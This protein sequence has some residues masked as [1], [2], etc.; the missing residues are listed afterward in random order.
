MRHAGNAYFSTALVFG[1]LAVEHPHLDRHALAVLPHSSHDS[2]HTRIAARRLSA[3]SD[4]SLTCA[5]DLD[6]IAKPWS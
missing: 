1:A 3:P 2:A 6:A 4:R 5:L